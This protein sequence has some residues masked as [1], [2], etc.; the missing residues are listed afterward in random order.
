MNDK[1]DCG[2]FCMVLELLEKRTT[3]KLMGGLDGN[4]WIIFT[5]GLKVFKLITDKRD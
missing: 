3:H 5:W 2:L 1:I 4:K